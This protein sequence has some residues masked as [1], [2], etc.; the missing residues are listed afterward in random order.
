MTEANL[1]AWRSQTVTNFEPLL[2]ELCNSGVV[3]PS[4]REILRYSV[5][6]AGK[7]IRPLLLIGLGED[8]G[9]PQQALLHAAAAVELLH[10]ASLVHDDLP[11]LDNDDMRRGKPSCHR[12]F[13]EAPALLAGDIA[14]PLAIHSVLGCAASLEVGAALA[15]ELSFAFMQVCN[16]QQLDL[17]SGSARGDVLSLYAQKTGALFGAA[18]ASAA[19]IALQ[20]EKV[21]NEA[22]RLGVELGVLFQLHDDAIDRTPEKGRQ[23]GS[24]LRNSKETAL[25]QGGDAAVSAAKDRTTEA[26]ERVEM[27]LI[28][29]TVCRELVRTRGVLGEVLGAEF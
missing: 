14:V 5:F 27:A 18:C 24:D 23:S 1:L 29:G 4:L 7:R 26:L 8:L 28:E 19:L 21:V 9:A 13:G 10:C 25:L 16:G 15:R 12:A 3:E 2:A 20:D 11:A 6:P 17:L 22:R